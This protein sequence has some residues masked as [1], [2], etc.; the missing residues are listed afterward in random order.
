MPRLLADIVSGLAGGA[1]FLLTYL[2]L[3]FSLLISLVIAGLIFAGL[4]LIF[5]RPAGDLNIQ[6]EDLGLTAE[7]VEATIVDGSRHVQEIRD[8]GRQVAAPTV[9]EKIDRICEQADAIL[10]HIAK[11]PRGV[12]TARRFL[13]Y[14]L[15]AVRNILKKYLELAEHSKYSDQVAD[16]VG[17]V[18]RLLD[19]VVQ[20]FAR[21]LA[22]LLEHQVLDIDTEVELLRQTMQAEGLL[23]PEAPK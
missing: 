15:D 2:W 18:E 13:T 8:L 21:Q 19:I 9:R 6:F 10:D 11:N 14:Y 1:A 20:A 17:K 7:M 3:D 5:H 4:A 23:I 16:V 22:R 12:K